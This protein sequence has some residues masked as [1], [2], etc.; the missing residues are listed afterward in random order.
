MSRN[1]DYTTMKLIRL[2]PLSKLLWTYWYRFTKF[3]EL[4]NFTGRLEK[5]G[6][7]TMFFIAEK[8]QKLF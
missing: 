6:C 7:E 4:I 1:D 5:D 2:F 8:Q 3:L